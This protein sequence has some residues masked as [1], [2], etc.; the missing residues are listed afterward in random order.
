MIWT[1]KIRKYERG[2][3]FRDKEFR[4]ALRPGRHWILDPLF[5][6]NAQVV[7]V[8]DVWLKWQRPG[9]ALRYLD[10]RRAE[11]RLSQ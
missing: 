11:P 10:A 1:I 5:R 9:N 7:S 8:R 6:A 2:L 4:K 3:L